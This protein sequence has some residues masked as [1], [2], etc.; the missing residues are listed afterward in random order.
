MRVLNP[1]IAAEDLPNHCIDVSSIPLIASLLDCV[2]MVV[3]KN[4]DKSVVRWGYG[5]EAW[6]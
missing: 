1:C 2:C 5:A 6:P 4:Y 3:V